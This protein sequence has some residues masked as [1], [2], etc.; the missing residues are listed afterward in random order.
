MKTFLQ[1]RID[2]LLHSMYGRAAL[3]GGQNGNLKRSG[4]FYNACLQQSVVVV[5]LEKRPA[6]LSFC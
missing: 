1:S 6:K 3:E 4:I 5:Q 2:P